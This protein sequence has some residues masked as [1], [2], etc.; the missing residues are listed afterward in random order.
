MGMGLVALDVV[1]GA[2]EGA[3]PE[4]F[5]GGTC[6]NVLT[7]LSFLGWRSEPVSRLGDGEVAELVVRDLRRWDVSEEFIWSDP[8][9]KT[10]VVIQTISKKGDGEPRHRFSWRC[11]FCGGY[12][13][14]YR[15]VVASAVRE[16]A[17][18][19]ERTDVFFFDRV[20]RGALVLAEACRKRGS[21]VVFEPSG[22]HAGAWVVGGGVGL[23]G[24]CEVLERA[25]GRCWRGGAWCVWKGRSGVGD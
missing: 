7:V 8:D 13:A 17:E 1:F 11:P 23:G 19:I 20:S 3:F 2:E 16:V 9:A 14:R 6:G 12:L 18:R 24:R 22:G 21:A 4:C 15:P 10:P 5:A 25:G